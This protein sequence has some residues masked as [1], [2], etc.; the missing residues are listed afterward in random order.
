MHE[1][2]KKKINQIRYFVSEY[3]V[4]VNL[5]FGYKKIAL[6]SIII[7][8]LLAYLDSL[9]VVLKL[10]SVHSIVYFLVVITILF[11]LFLFIRFKRYG[12]SKEVNLFDFVVNS[13]IFI[14]IIC[15]F[16][17]VILTSDLLLFRTPYW[18]YLIF[19]FICI[20]MIS[21]KIFIRNKHVTSAHIYSLVDLTQGKI[22]NTNFYLSDKPLEKDL[23]GQDHVIL[24]ILNFTKTLIMKEP[25]TIALRGKWGTGK[26]S[27]LNV[28]KEKLKDDKDIIVIDQFDPWQYNDEISMFKGLLKAITK[29]LGITSYF[30]LTKIDTFISNY[31]SLPKVGP[32]LRLLKCDFSDDSIIDIINDK[33]EKEN[34]KLIIIMDNID[35]ATDDNILLIY[36][37]ISSIIKLNK[38]LYILAYDQKIIEQKLLHNNIDPSFIDKIVQTSIDIPIVSSYIMN[39]NFLVALSE[40]GKIYGIDELNKEN[41]EFRL[42]KLNGFSTYRDIVIFLNDILF[43]LSKERNLNYIDYVILQ[44]IKCKDFELYEFIRENPKLFVSCHDNELVCNHDRNDAQLLVDIFNVEKRK[45]LLDIVK[46]IFPDIEDRLKN[47]KIVYYKNKP[48]DL[49]YRIASG[50]YFDSYFS[51]DFSKIIDLEKDKK[52]RYVLENIKRGKD[53]SID[54]P[55]IITNY[56]HEEQNVVFALLTNELRKNKNE[57]W[58]NVIKCLIDNSNFFERNTENRSTYFLNVDFVYKALCEISIKDFEQVKIHFN[59][60]NKINFIQNLLWKH[61][62]TEEK[63][64]EFVFEELKK[65]KE[66]LVTK[67]IDENINIYASENYCPGNVKSFKNSLNVKEY[68]KN[69]LDP[70]NVLNFIKEFIYYAKS[71]DNK[72]TKYH[73]YID[74]N[75]CLS[76]VD[77]EN[78]NS[79]IKLIDR[80][81]IDQEERIILGIYDKTDFTKTEKVESPF[82]HDGYV[83]IY[84]IDL[85]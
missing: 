71:Y 81:N 23:F 9:D 22:L 45:N 38:T 43:V 16:G 82:H 47:K 25:Y 24:Q 72:F 79:I 67:V 2:L 12:I 41:S 54:L 76:Y 39:Q 48:Y 31:Y 63:R 62:G 29:K 83:S 49:E 32:F 59:R 4:K 34:K 17:S 57:H 11:F 6:S 40:I 58:T 35:R 21:L 28:V 8:C 77:Y 44:Y 18:I 73:Y 68:L 61:T 7:S 27:I 52:L 53:V 19:I 80:T 74:V 70:N 1:K 42:S 85:W 69:V 56:R 66:E 36:K 75:E 26:S 33:L 20:S 13:F 60:I 78:L 15:L 55:I 64:N 46:E 3:I 30:N 65:I 5:I 84:K 50:R 37:L 14:G 10:L 51:N